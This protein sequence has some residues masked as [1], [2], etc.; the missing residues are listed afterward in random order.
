MNACVSIRPRRVTERSSEQVLSPQHNLRPRTNARLTRRVTPLSTPI[1]IG[2]YHSF[3]A[4]LGTLPQ[5]APFQAL[6]KA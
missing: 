1:Q 6:V 4:K 5:L 2:L 3:K